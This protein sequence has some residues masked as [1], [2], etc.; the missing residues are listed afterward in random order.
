MINY[1]VLREIVSLRNLITTCIEHRE[2][3][4]LNSIDVRMGRFIKMSER[5]KKGISIK[6]SY[7]VSDCFFL[8]G[9]PLYI[10]GSGAN[11]Y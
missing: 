3:I 2:R 5:W 7:S 4:G 10:Y 11:L 1:L 6:L 9:T 8:M